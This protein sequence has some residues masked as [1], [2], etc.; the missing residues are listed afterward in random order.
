MKY[1]CR[2]WAPWRTARSA[3]ITSTAAGIRRRSSIC[4]PT[5]T[6]SKRKGLHGLLP[7]PAIEARAALAAQAA[8]R[9]QLAQERRRLEA[10]LTEGLEEH[11]G[12]AL[13][14]VE[15]HVIAEVQGAHRSE[16]HT[17]EL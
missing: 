1:P 16:E 8:R 14:G 7:F 17:S 6:R 3:R 15:A 4:Q 2:R 10:W 12:H 5:G 11:F 13:Q 9:H